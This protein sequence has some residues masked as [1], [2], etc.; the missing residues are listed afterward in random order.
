MADPRIEQ[1]AIR[2]VFL[3]EKVVLL[4][5]AGLSMAVPTEMEGGRQLARRI[6]QIAHDVFPGF[7]GSE[8]L[9]IV[10]DEL[11]TRHDALGTDLFLRTFQQ[12]GPNY[13][14]ENEGHIS[15]VKL[16]LEDAIEAIYSLNVD[17]LIEKAAAS[18]ILNAG[19]EDARDLRGNAATH[20]LGLRWSAH[21]VEG[22]APQKLVKIHGCIV[23]E[24]NGTV[25]SGAALSR[26]DWPDNASWAMPGFEAHVQSHTLVIV[27]CGAPVAYLNASIQRAKAVAPE[28]KIFYLVSIDTFQDYSVNLNPGLVNSARIT[29]ESFLRMN[30]SDFL[31]DLHAEVCRTVLNEIESALINRIN[32]APNYAVPNSVA[33]VESAALK[34]S[35]RQVG[36]HFREDLDLLQKFLRR[37]LLWGKDVSPPQFLLYYISIRLNRELLMDLWESVGMIKLVANA[38]QLD[39]SQAIQSVRCGVAAPILII[40]CRGFFPQQIR[41]NLF[42]KLIEVRG[43]ALPNKLTVLLVRANATAEEIKKIPPKNRSRALSSISRAHVTSD[44]PATW[45]ITTSRD[46]IDK[47]PFETAD[48]W[49]QIMLTQLALN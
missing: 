40:H 27:G 18:R 31:K 32:D 38:C 47:A 11:S 19:W 33:R 28:N 10:Y 44:L 43:P 30:G 14:P 22:P 4:V 13:Y 39:D 16:F 3:R 34:E 21:G 46:T 9:G 49:K 36:Q 37:A 2:I 7:P 20:T 8:D 45:I 25:W 48:Q 17:D 35:V 26:Q 12:V 23:R 42:S 15:I 29:E 5:G 24:P 6:S 1:L 41:D